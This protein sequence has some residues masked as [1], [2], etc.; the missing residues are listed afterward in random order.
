MKQWWHS[1]AVYQVYPRSFQDSNSDGIGDLNGIISRLDY[2][3]KLG[4]TIIW[5]CPVYASPMADNGYDISDYCSIAPEYGTMDDMKSLISAINARGMHLIMDLVLNHTSSAHPWFKEACQSKQNPYR[6]F[7]IWRAPDSDGNPP[8]FNPASHFGG[9]MWTL[10]NATG[11][12]YFHQFASAQPDLNWRNP[13]VQQEAHKIINWWLA[14]GISGFRL[15]VIDLLGKDIDAGILANGPQLHKLLRN[16][17][18]QCFAGQQA[19]TVGEVWS[20]T[21]MTAKLMTRPARQELSMLFQFE[22][23]LQL[24]HPEHGKWQPV[25]FSIA[26]YKQQLERWQTQIDDGWVAQF[27]GNHDLPR[28]V[29]TF[30]NSTHWRERSAKALAILQ[31]SLKGTPYIYQGEEIGMTNITLDSIEDYRDIETL[32]HYQEKRA[33][34]WPHED[35]MN[36]IHQHGRDN[37]RTPMQWNS[38]ANAGFT[39]G[40]PWLTVNSN[41]TSINVGQALVDPNSI[42]Y[43]YQQLIALRKAWQVLVYGSFQ[44]LAH[45]ELIVFKRQLE[46]DTALLVINLTDQAL[47]YDSSSDAFN[48]VVISSVDKRETISGTYQPYEAALFSL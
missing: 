45:N 25:P 20:A 22:H 47:Q 12:Y 2:L 39:D 26:A 8:S 5:L 23:I 19:I 3:E 24:H 29:S 28:A 42:Y 44:M 48:E 1:A 40:Q 17:N 15:D 9:S 13:D 21:P 10:D 14:K 30:G 4:I 41:Y 46:G 7:Y 35:I 36:G 33:Q 18:E 32:N 31:F 16:M 27:W 6:D 11:E 38:D 43:C 37:A 34:G